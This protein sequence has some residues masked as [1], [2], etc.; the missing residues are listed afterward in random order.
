MVGP[1]VGG[2][3]DQQDPHRKNDD[4]DELMNQPTFGDGISYA[5]YVMV[6]PLKFCGTCR[7]QKLN[8]QICLEVLAYLT[9]LYQLYMLYRV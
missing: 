7:H 6:L 1:D 4:S 2:G 3:T 5:L 8:E 9:T